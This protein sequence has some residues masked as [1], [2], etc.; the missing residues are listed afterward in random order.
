MGDGQNRAR[1]GKAWLSWLTA[2]VL[3]VSAPGVAHA[4]C[5]QVKTT[6]LEA[7]FQGTECKSDPRSLQQISRLDGLYTYLTN[8]EALSGTLFQRTMYGYAYVMKSGKITSPVFQGTLQSVAQANPAGKVQAQELRQGDQDL[9]FEGQFL[10]DITLS[11]QGEMTTQEKHGDLHGP[12]FEGRLDAFEQH[13]L[14]ANQHASEE[15]RSGAEQ[16]GNGA[17]FL[18]D[19]HNRRQ[20]NLRTTEK[21][22]QIQ[23]PTF[24][25]TLNAFSQDD[26]TPYGRQSEELRSG[27][28]TAGTGWFEGDSHTV[29]RIEP[30]NTG[31]GVFYRGIVYTEK[32]GNL[33][34]NHFAGQLHSFVQ[35]TGS[36]Y[37][38]SD[39]LRSGSERVGTEG[40]FYGDTHEMRQAN[41]LYVLERHGQVGSAA[42]QGTLQSF[43]QYDP[44]AQFS[45]APL[46][47]PSNGYL[48]ADYL[49]SGK[50]P[51]G[52][53]TYVGD[54]H[55][56]QRNKHVTVEDR[57]VEAP[58]DPCNVS[59]SC[60]TIGERLGD[61]LPP[62]TPTP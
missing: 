40:L 60:G 30:M 34:D 20:N 53:K 29:Q 39:E 55:V 7:T 16:M 48:Q 31:K 56:M 26:G 8:R 25:G 41:G 4:A 15:L 58:S 28:E 18:G 2:N 1:V 51:V 62:L 27:R 23:G 45:C 46:P 54:L 12:S 42:F 24:H 37:P 52:N 21:H 9:G 59:A 33:Y 17:R 32:H 47:C 35:D 19:I 36:L 50:W 11:R 43:Y 5:A 44:S 10:G 6:S 22:G 38:Q 14:A 57:R 49:L 61:A 13:D 3:L